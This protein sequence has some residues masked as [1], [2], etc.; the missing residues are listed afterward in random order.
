MK[1]ERTVEMIC[2]YS[3]FTDNSVIWILV[4]ASGKGFPLPQSSSVRTAEPDAE[5]YHI[6]I[7]G[8]LKV[9]NGMI[10]IVIIVNYASIKKNDLKA[11]QNEFCQ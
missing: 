5:R 2:W 7:I 11:N 3:F 6:K 10:I 1:C 4:D 9:I 8:K